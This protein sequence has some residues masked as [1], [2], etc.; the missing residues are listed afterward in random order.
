[1]A[2]TLKSD[3]LLFVITMLLVGA[4]LIMVFSASAS[5]ALKYGGPAY[6]LKKQALWALMGFVSMAVAMRVDYRELRKPHVIWGLL[7]LKK[8]Y[9]SSGVSGDYK[10]YEE[11]LMGNIASG[12]MPG[13]KKSASDSNDIPASRSKSG[14]SKAGRG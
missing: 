9:E 2:R 1:M 13:W 12:A 7:A 6:F 5:T 11:K 14:L 10:V 3:K 8:G 4:S